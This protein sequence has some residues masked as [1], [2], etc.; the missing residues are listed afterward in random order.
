MPQKLPQSLSPLHKKKHEQNRTPHQQ[1]IHFRSVAQCWALNTVNLLWYFLDLHRKLH[2]FGRKSERNPS[3]IHSDH[4]GS[5]FRQKNIWSH[6]KKTI[7]FLH[8]PHQ[9]LKLPKTPH[10]CNQFLTQKILEKMTNN[11]E[12]SKA[13]DYVKSLKL[14][15]ADYPALG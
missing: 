8:E 14:N 7:P 9:V 4:Q 15:P 10:Q 11:K 2:F 1:V 13:A 12:A 6:R 3:Q 5:R